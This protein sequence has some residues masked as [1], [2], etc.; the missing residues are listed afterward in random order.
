MDCFAQLLAQLLMQ[1]MVHNLPDRDAAI[2]GWA[3]SHG[4]TGAIDS[5]F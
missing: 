2:C 5:L 3:E 1:H 4:V